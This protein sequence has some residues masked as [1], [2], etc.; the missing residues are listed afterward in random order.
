MWNVNSKKVFL[1]VSCSEK[2]TATAVSHSE[3]YFAAASI[4]GFVYIW[5]TFSG[6]LIKK[7]KAH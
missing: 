4:T 6:D 1:R 2:I 7:Y 3:L 5:E